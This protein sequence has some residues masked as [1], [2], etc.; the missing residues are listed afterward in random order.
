M[1]LV[2]LS[3]VD[4]GPGELYSLFEWLQRDDELR[5]RIKAS[6]GESRPDEMGGVVEMLSVALSSGGAG[7]V[8]AG[9]LATWLQTRRARI[10]VE[11]ISG[12]SGDIVRKVEVDAGSPATTKRLLRGVLAASEEA[13]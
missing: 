4:G 10:S 1:A 2:N 6:S 5:G 7:A 3:T 9:S 11:V 8:L 13:R 12:E